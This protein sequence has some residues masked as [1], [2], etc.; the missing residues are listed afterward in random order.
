MP[1]FKKIVIQKEFK[2]LLNK[3]LE[4]PLKFLPEQLLT[5]LKPKLVPFFHAPFW[6]SESGMEL[7]Y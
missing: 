2:K 3:W 7:E 6:P 1:F 4:N 5:F